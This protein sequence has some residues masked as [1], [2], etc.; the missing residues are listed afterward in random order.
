MAR[1]K[2]N[3]ALHQVLAAARDTLVR[4]GAYWR[5]GNC[6]N[7]ATRI[8][9]HIPCCLFHADTARCGSDT[10]MSSIKHPQAELVSAIEAYDETTE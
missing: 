1:F 5:S 9:A 2:N 6:P 8:V 10:P 3:K 4:C 7:L